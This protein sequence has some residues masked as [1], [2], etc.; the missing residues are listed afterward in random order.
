M[1]PRASS[2][3]VGPSSPI[4]AYL[5]PREAAAH[6]GVHVLSLARWRSQGRGPK[7]VQLSRRAVRYA[8]SE[9]DRYCAE[10]TKQSTAA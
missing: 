5:T 7:W 2:E 1:L 9:L 4:A 8:R 6:L 10:N 3:P